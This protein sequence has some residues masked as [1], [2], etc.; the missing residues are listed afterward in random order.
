GGAL[1]I[2]YSFD[3]LA[4]EFFGAFLVDHYDFN[5]PTPPPGTS[6]N[7][8]Q[9]SQNGG[10]TGVDAFFGAGGRITSHDSTVRFTA[11]LAPALTASASTTGSKAAAAGAPATPASTTAPPPTT[12]TAAAR[13]Q[14]AMWRRASCSTAACLSGIP[15]A[16]SSSSASRPGWTS[17]RRSSLDPTRRRRSPR[18]T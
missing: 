4:L 1:H 12:T 2:G 5:A 3:V 10:V 7:A 8:S 9:N 11:A 14:L 15:L 18:A 17:R 13:A 6:P 16:P